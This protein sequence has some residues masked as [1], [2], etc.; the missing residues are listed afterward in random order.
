MRKGAPD[1]PTIAAVR[2]GILAL[3][4]AYWEPERFRAEARVAQRE[5]AVMAAG[6][7]YQVLWED[8]L[9]KEVAADLGVAIEK[10]PRP[11][12]VAHA[13]VAIM[14]AGFAAWFQDDCRGDPVEVVASTFDRATPALEAV[15]AMPSG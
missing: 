2:R 3:T 1:E 13:T 11:R 15:L 7:A 14:R 5:P 6:L 10:D 9:A 8:M 4:E 12:I